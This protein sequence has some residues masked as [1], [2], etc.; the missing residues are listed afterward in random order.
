MPIFFQ[1]KNKEIHESER[2]FTNLNILA[3]AQILEIDIGSVCG[4]HG[5]CGKDRI[6]ILE[7]ASHCSDLTQDEL[8]HLSQTELQ[9]GFRLGCQCF[10]NNESANYFIQY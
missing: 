2:V 4:G 10:P 6:Q 1:N 3:H 7:G 5:K 9:N 8:K